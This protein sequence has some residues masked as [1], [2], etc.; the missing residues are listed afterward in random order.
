[1]IGVALLGLIRWESCL[2][3]IFPP[4]PL[5]LPSS[6]FCPSPPPSHLLWCPVL[7]FPLSFTL[8]L[9]LTSL[10]S[11]SVFL[12]SP[13]LLFPPSSSPLLQTPPPPPNTFFPPPLLIAFPLLYFKTNWLTS[14]YIS[15]TNV[16]RNT[17][18]KLTLYPNVKIFKHFAT[19]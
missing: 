17:T 8:L 15:S 3:A 16:C 4:C 18:R 2:L 6:L 10:Y 7:T 1:M 5:P 9:S 11:F 19:P 13:R 12:S 14:L